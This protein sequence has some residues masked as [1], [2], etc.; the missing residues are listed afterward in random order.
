M[1]DLG[2]SLISLPEL[3]LLCVPHGL[4]ILFLTI[5]LLQQVVE[6]I[7]VT[8]DAIHPLGVSMELVP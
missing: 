1:I 3:S 5:Q 2:L 4:M 7:P 8:T 6:A